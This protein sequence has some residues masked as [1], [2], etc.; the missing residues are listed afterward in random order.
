MFTIQHIADG[1]PCIGQ[2]THKEYVS[3]Q[4]DTLRKHIHIHI[5]MY[6]IFNA[7]KVENLIFY[8]VFIQNIDCE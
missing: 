4:A 1:T 2:E 3:I 8:I 6:N 7:V 5:T